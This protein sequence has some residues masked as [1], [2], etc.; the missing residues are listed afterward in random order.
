[1]ILHRLDAKLRVHCSQQ[2]VFFLALAVLPVAKPL[3]SELYGIFSWFRRVLCKRELLVLENYL[4][5]WG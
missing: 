3:F 1:M 2:F 5:S 4:R